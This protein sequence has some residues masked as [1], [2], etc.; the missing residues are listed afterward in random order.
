M[1][2][3]DDPETGVEKMESCRVGVV[4][5]GGGRARDAATS[6]WLTL[7]VPICRCVKNVVLCGLLCPLS[8][9]GFFSRG[10]FLFVS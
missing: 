9:L 1:T 3:D 2:L 8:L 5:Q 10:L 6:S 4:T 7:H